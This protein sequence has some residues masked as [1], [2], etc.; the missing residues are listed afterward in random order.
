MSNFFKAKVIKNIYFKLIEVTI[1]DV[2]FIQ[3]I[4][5]YALAC[6]RGR[7]LWLYILRMYR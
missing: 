5:S 2:M 4:L 1:N 3:H 6:I 7:G